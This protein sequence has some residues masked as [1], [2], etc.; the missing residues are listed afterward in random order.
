M[1]N[2]V[3]YDIEFDNDGT[4]WKIATIKKMKNDG[5]CAV[6]KTESIG[7]N[8]LYYFNHDILYTNGNKP[9]RGSSKVIALHF[10]F[11]KI[12]TT[13]GQKIKIE[14]EPNNNG[15]G[16]TIKYPINIKKKQ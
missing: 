12:S 10:H 13:V 15:Y 8:D 4:I 9:P 2:L 6:S 16:Y 11:W 3:L 1:K 14:C 5:R 7:V